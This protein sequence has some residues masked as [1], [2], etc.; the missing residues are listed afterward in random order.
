MRQPYSKEEI[1]DMV[2]FLEGDIKN[3]H[4]NRLKGGRSILYAQLGRDYIELLEKYDDLKFRMR[5]LEK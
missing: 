4:I 2:K 5:G 3:Y 1:E